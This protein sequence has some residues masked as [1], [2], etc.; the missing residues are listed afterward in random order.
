MLKELCYPL[1]SNYVLR[2]KKSLKKKLEEFDILFEKRVAILGGSTTNEIKNILELF[3]L[4]VRIKPTF[5]ESGFNNYYEEALFDTDKLLDFK[6]DI[7]IIHT[8]IINIENSF[9]TI[10]YNSDVG[11]IIDTTFNKFHS[12]WRSLSKFDCPIIQNNFDT[13]VSIDWKK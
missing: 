11:T 10:G 4:N 6:P 8:T 5:Y 2:K 13:T 3:L 9:D 1:D 7:I 12:I